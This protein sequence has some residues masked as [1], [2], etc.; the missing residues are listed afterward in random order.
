MRKNT[1]NL[2]DS[3]QARVRHL[4]NVE[5]RMHIRCQSATEAVKNHLKQVATH[6]QNRL[7]KH[8]AKLGPGQEI[9]DARFDH[10]EAGLQI[11]NGDRADHLAYMC[12]LDA[13]KRLV[14]AFHWLSESPPGSK[15]RCPGRI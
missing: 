8:L 10:I 11:S 5:Y 7:I 13:S 6:A 9:N 1:K 3:V 14:P 4:C 15:S 2:L 12:V